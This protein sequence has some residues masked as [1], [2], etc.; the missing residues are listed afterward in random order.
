[1]PGTEKYGWTAIKKPEYVMGRMGA[2]AAMQDGVGFAANRFAELWRANLSKVGSGL[3]V[4]VEFRT[5]TR[6]GKTSVMPV[7]T[8]R[9]PRRPS[10]PGDYPAKQS[11][12]LASSIKVKR[13]VFTDPSR[14]PGRVRYIVG[15]NLAYAAF[16]EWGVGPGRPFRHPAKQRE[17][18]MGQRDPEDVESG[19]TAHRPFVIEPRPHLRTT[20]RT[21]MVGI[22]QDMLVHIRG[23][24]VPPTLQKLDIRHM[25]RIL[26]KASAKLGSLQLFGI[27]SRFLFLIRQRAIK[28]ERLLGDYGAVIDGEMWGRVRRR[29]VGRNLGL[30][31]GKMAGA[32][33]GDPRFTKAV[34]RQAR[35][36]LGSLF[37]FLIR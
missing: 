8:A 28:A 9:R 26:L 6:G 1:M 2:T 21:S 20:L 12:E 29:I 34:K 5:V 37:G 30:T 22:N 31:I 4:N 23:A 17:R 18:R 25:R 19:G 14:G 15:T 32:G 10:R 7:G 3:P 36:T 27:N 11:G 24:L 16:L 13:V 33:R 35:T